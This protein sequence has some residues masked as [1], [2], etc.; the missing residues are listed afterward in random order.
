MPENAAASAAG[1][2]DLRLISSAL[3][4]I[5]DME[6]IGDQAADISEIVIYL[7]EKPKNQDDGAFAE[8]G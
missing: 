4:M 7:A 2:E 3:K 6:R 8:D 5:T 1:S